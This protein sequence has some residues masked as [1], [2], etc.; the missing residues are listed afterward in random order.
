[1]GKSLL[2]KEHTL[3]HRG[4][5]RLVTIVLCLAGLAV[6]LFCVMSCDRAGE[7]HSN[8][9]GT[10]REA[11]EAGAKSEKAKVTFIELGSVKCIPCK[12]MQ[13]IMKEIEEEYKGQVRV[14]FYDVWTNEGRPY[15]RKYRIRVIPTQVFLDKDGK[16]YFRHEGFFPKDD[17]VGVLKQQGVKGQ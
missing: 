6:I 7:Q 4:C 12:R 9:E 8:A 16:E 15:A 1:M 17:L 11:G 5:S 13:P 3:D 14:I 10:G 2:F